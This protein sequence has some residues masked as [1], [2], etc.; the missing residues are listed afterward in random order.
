MAF[1]K[2]LFGRDGAALKADVERYLAEGNPVRAWEVADRWAAVAPVAER[3][4]AARYLGRSRRAVLDHVLE[5]AA[6]AEEAGDW[7]DAVDWLRS[8]LERAR[9][10]DERRGLEDRLKGALARQEEEELHERRQTYTE[11]PIDGEEGDDE[12]FDA[13]DTWLGTLEPEFALLYE[14]RPEEFRRAVMAINEGRVEEALPVL[15][16]LVAEGSDPLARFERGRARILSGDLTGAREDLEAVWGELPVGPLDAGRTLSVPA[17]WAEA[18]LEQGEPEALAELIERLSAHL[19]P[20]GELGEPVLVELGGRALL[21]LE[22][23]GELRRL[24]SAA[25]SLYPA[26]PAL[27]W[28]LARALL[29]EGEPR[30]AIEALETALRR[31][32]RTGRRTGTAL[33]PPVLRTLAA[34]Y[35]ARGEELERADELLRMTAQAQGGAWTAED[36]ELAARLYRLTAM[37]EQAEQAAAAAERL[38]AEGPGAVVVVAAVAGGERGRWSVV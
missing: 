25:T 12:P 34:L 37:E 24:A 38:R 22:R 21:A 1:L 26:M 27:P 23:F 28:L 10:V 8:A 20:D 13:Y 19:D 7:T 32:S 29:G 18:V 11:G 33:H 16:G 9:E 36:F 14:D 17:L 4:E 6:A 31:D 35:V 2:R 3:E 30:L 15:D 5:R